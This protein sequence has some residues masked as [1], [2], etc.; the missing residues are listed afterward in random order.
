MFEGERQWKA[1]VWKAKAGLTPTVS[2][3][4]MPRMTRV[5]NRLGARI[6]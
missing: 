1:V 2:I 3:G 6:L 5:K 4:K